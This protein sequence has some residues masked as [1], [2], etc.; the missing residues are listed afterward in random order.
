MTANSCFDPREKDSKS[1]APGTKED[2][3]VENKSEF[4]LNNLQIQTNHAIDDEV[5]RIMSK[6]FVENAR[7]QD[8]V[9]KDPESATVEVRNK[10]IVV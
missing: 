10:K 8:G 1:K 9:A 7:K 6:F 4:W 2:K 5:E 3:K